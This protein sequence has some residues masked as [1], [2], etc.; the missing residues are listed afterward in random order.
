MHSE[1]LRA[2]MFIFD[3]YP[4]RV[5]GTRTT[6]IVSGYGRAVL[7]TAV[8]LYYLPGYGRT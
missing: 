6:S 1:R 2:R 3:V 5:Y 4:D 8:Q 7:Y